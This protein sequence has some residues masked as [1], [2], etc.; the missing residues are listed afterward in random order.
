MKEEIRAYIVE[1]KAKNEVRYI[2]MGSKHCSEHGK[3]LLDTMYNNTLE[4]IK[5]LEAILKKTI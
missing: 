4:I 3:I 5:E 1:L 2:A